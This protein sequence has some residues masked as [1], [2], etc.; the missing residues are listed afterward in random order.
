MHRLFALEFVRVTEAAAIAAAKQMGHGDQ[1]KAD[2][3]AVEAMRKMLA[4]IEFDGTVQIGEGERDQAPMLYI[5]EKVGTG[6]G[7][8]LDVALDPL[9]GTALCAK[10]GPNALSIIAV[11]EGGNLLHAPDVY[12][13]KIAVGPEAAHVIDLEKSPSDNVRAVAKAKGKDLSHVTVVIMDR[14]RHAA[15]I[16]EV[17]EVGARII[18]ISDGDVQPALACG[19]EDSGI[20]LLMGIGGA[21]EGVISAAALKCLKGGFQGRLVF[22]KKGTLGEIDHEQM[23]RARDQMGIT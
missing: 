5:G 20:D 3:L 7:I 15:M 4:S 11:A 17:R 8:A 18:L 23:A 16:K 19:L 13:E 6:K 10:G 21:P 12:M 22:H 2:R 1:K 9:E 14:L